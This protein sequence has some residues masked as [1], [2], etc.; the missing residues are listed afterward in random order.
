MEGMLDVPLSPHQPRYTRRL[1]DKA[2]IAFHNA[3][4][5]YEVGVAEQLLGGL[6][7]MIKR[8]SA[9]S[10]GAERRAK[11]T[12]AAAHECLWQLRHPSSVG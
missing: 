8:P 12:L 9:S 1:S 4:D 7:F 10:T 6:E 2:L 3:C 5:Q 11:D